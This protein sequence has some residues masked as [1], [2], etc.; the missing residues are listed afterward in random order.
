MT[1]KNGAVAQLGEHRTCTAEV[2]GSNPV[3][4]TVLMKSIIVCMLLFFGCTNA[5][6][7][8]INYNT[9]SHYSDGKFSDEIPDSLILRMYGYKVVD[10]MNG[11]EH[12]YSTPLIMRQNSKVTMFCKVHRGWEDVRS[13]Y[14]LLDGKSGYGIVISRHKKF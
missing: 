2:A 6:N 3:S 7:G 4:S 13:T 12:A 14:L 5:P 1:N 8:A 11:T 10:D 9:T